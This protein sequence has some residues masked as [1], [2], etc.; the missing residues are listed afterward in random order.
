MQ[1]GEGWASVGPEELA[2]RLRQQTDC[3]QPKAGRTSGLV[4]LFGPE[5]VGWCAVEPRTEYARLLRNNRVPWQGR[6]EDKTDDSVWGLHL[7]RHAHGLPQAGHRVGAR[8]RRGPLR[9]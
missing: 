9:Q 2:F 8:P 7:L 1:P 3:G 4:A 5:P 6:S